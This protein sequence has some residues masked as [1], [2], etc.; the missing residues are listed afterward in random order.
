VPIEFLRWASERAGFTIAS[1]T[2]QAEWLAGLGIDELVAEGDDT[3]RARAHLGDLEAVAGRSRGVEAAALT[4][5]T[6]LGAHR[7]VTLTRP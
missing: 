4:D 5:P 6:G 7:V 1:E 2:T 3:W